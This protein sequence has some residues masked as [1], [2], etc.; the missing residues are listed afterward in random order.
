[1]CVCLYTYTLH[2]LITYVF[3]PLTPFPVVS[4]GYFVYNGIDSTVAKVDLPQDL[5]FLF[6]IGDDFLAD[7]SEL[8]N[9]HQHS[10][11]CNYFI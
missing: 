4:P 5:F 7:V 2:I 3:T 8:L 11:F 6:F 1:M 9:V 10:S